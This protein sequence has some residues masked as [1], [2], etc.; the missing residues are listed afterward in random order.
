MFGR[1]S[2]DPEAAPQSQQTP[3][4]G[5]GSSA[6]GS[7]K[8]QEA[9]ADREASAAAASRDE[10]Q[11]AR[12]AART[13][14]KGRP[15]PSRRQQEAAR[16]QPLVPEDRKAAKAQD[17]AARRESRLTAQRGMAAGDVRYLPPRDQGEQRAFARD[18]VDARWNVAEVML[19]VALI[20]LVFLLIPTGL[21][22]IGLFIFYALIVLTILDTILMVVG[23]R[24]AITRTFG[25]RER[26]IGFYA[27]TRAM[28]I[29]STRMPRPRNKRGQK[30]A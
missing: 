12:S 29:R 8:A 30:P 11:R 20:S 19:P 9:A 4:R 6:V 28:N 3:S 16:I 15:T 5:S 22:T 13:E 10:A 7:P 18:W 24:R 1:R 27:A 21:Q 2:R 17:R 23:L 14:G 25:E 26:G